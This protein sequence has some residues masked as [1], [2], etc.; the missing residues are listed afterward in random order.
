MRESYFMLLDSL[1]GRINFSVFPGRQLYSIL[2]AKFNGSIV[3]LLSK[4]EKVFVLLD[5]DFHPDT[6]KLESLEIL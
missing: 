3:S 5:P 2:H 1:S 6:D 4:I